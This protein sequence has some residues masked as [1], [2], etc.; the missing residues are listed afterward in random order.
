MNIADL[1]Y[2]SMKS[3][4]SSYN[5][6]FFAY[7]IKTYQLSEDQKQQVI[8]QSDVYLA[9]LNHQLDIDLPSIPVLFDL[10]GK[11]SGM[12]RVKLDEK[13]IR[14]NEIIFSRYFEDAL[15]N[16]T[17]HE[18]AHYVAHELYGSRNIRPHGREWQSL[19]WCL[20]VKPEVTSQYDLSGLPLRQQ[21]QFVYACECMQHQLS[22][23]RHNRVARQRAIYNC[24][25][26]LQPLRF[27]EPVTC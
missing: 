20:D 16:T 6:A 7:M 15:I 1:V 24:R 2:Y 3:A 27:I 11:S 13:V 5:D 21:K 9:Q 17:A 18:I 10:N 4:I 25:K 12:F 26:C 23:T 19:M 14:Y 8:E 22:S